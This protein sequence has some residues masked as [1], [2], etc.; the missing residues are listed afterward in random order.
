MAPVLPLLLLPTICRNVRTSKKEALVNNRGSVGQLG[1][2]RFCYNK[3]LFIYA[4]PLTVD[5]NGGGDTHYNNPN[6]R[7]DNDYNPLAGGSEISTSG[8]DSGRNSI[9]CGKHDFFIQSFSKKRKNHYVDDIKPILSEWTNIEPNLLSHPPELH[10]ISWGLY[11][12]V[13]EQINTKDKSGKALSH[14]NDRKYS[15]AKRKYVEIGSAEKARNKFVSE[16]V[17]GLED[18]LESAFYNLGIKEFRFN[19][20]EFYNLTF[21]IRAFGKSSLLQTLP[22]LKEDPKPINGPY[23]TTFT[24]ADFPI[25]Q[26]RTYRNYRIRQLI[27]IALQ[28]NAG[29]MKQIEDDIEQDKIAAGRIQGR[30]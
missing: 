22:P 27:N 29:N 8:C 20:Y 24:L 2:C 18:S 14:L 23:Y 26:C 6:Y 5:N 10:P 7:A 25:A 1:V 12:N 9:D 11:T 13:I 3:S 21:I 19:R 30:N 28:K 15:E 4:Y 16:S 17:H